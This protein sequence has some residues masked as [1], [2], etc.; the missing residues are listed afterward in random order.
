MEASTTTL[1]DDDTS[2][3]TLN[4]AEGDSNTAGTPRIMVDRVP[5]AGSGGS[6]GGDGSNS[7]HYHH[8]NHPTINESN[9]VY[10]KPPIPI[11]KVNGSMIRTQGGRETLSSSARAGAGT[12][13]A[14]EVMNDSGSGRRSSA[15][16]VA[17]RE[18]APVRVP[19]HDKEKRHRASGG[20]GCHRSETIELE[21][22]GRAMRCSTPRPMTSPPA[23][24]RDAKWHASTV[25]I[26][27]CTVFHVLYSFTGICRYLS[28]KTFHV[29]SR[30]SH[31]RPREPEEKKE[32]KIMT[33]REP[34][35]DEK[36][37]QNYPRNGGIL[38]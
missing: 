32:E 2:V 27:C 35:C 12:G 31:N 15:S 28:S 14:G 17:S 3:D 33:I 21:S 23:T 36:P 16:L 6:G 22:S 1:G 4:T 13:E 34:A 5:Q 38:T 10:S 11:A 8:H 7:H 29:T 18:N 25:C 26:I 9:G 20:Y 30:F 19:S 37:T 24:F